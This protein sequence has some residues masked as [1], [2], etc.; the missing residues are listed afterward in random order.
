MQFGS[1]ADDAGTVERTAI[2]W[3]QK[4]MHSAAAQGEKHAMT[5]GAMLIGLVSEPAS[6][7]PRTL[8]IRA[9][10]A[11]AKQH[12]T[13]HELRRDFGDVTGDELQAEATADAADADQV[14]K[15]FHVGYTAAYFISSI[16]ITITFACS[17]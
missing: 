17:G 7:V 3:L 9:A 8:N 5:Q 2:H 14:G 12:M 15:L 11:Y 6:A 4:V 13:Q 16:I 10:L 1:K